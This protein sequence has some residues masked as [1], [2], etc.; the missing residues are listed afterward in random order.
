[1]RK[2]CRRKV[3]MLVDPIRHAMTGAAVADSGVLDQL[4][5]REL[6]ALEA[7]R[8]GAATRADWNSLADLLNIAETM[9][10]NGVGRDEVLPVC[11]RAQQ[12]L[13]AAQK[14]HAATGH[15]GLDGPG[16]QALREL[17]EYH[18]LQRTSISRAEYERAIQRTANRIR[19]ANQRVKV[20]V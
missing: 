10:S 7:F 2:K 15:L 14:R 3:Y 5:I 13:E 11:E 8:T 18:D 6:S 9:A 1:M 20:L 12:A 4:R 16:L 17:A 19:S